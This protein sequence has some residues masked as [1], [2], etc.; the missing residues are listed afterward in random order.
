MK[1]LIGQ[2]KGEGMARNANSIEWTKAQQHTKVGCFQ[3][4]D[5]EFRIDGGQNR[6]G[7][8]Q[9]VKLKSDAGT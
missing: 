5:K 8:Q 1:T 2:I 4:T 3:G 9:T 6:E 7:E